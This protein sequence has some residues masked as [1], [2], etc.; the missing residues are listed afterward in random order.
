MD[1]IAERCPVLIHLSTGVGLE[2]PYEERANL[3]KL[4]P[5]MATLNACTMSFG[6][7]EFRNPPTPVRR[8]AARMQELDVKPDLEI[9]DTAH[10]DACLR[11]RGE[12]L[13][14]DTPQFSIVLGVRGGIAATADNL[15]T[16][17]RRLPPTPCGRSSPSDVPTSN[18]PRSDSR[19]AATPERGWKTPSTS[20][21]ADSPTATH[22]SWNAPY[23]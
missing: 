8:L 22:R 6:G 4:R 11:L 18:S 21:G 1:L 15:L 14:S 20:A 23:D 7:G 16:V 19:W 13:L 3:V 10:L 9:Y 12:G 17:V 5:S 2:V